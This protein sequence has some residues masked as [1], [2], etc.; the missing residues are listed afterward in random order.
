MK[1]KIL[2]RAMLMAACAAGCFVVVHALA[3][4]QRGYI[5][6]GGELVCLM[7][8]PLGMSLLEDKS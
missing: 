4:M 3:T 8:I 7:A 5:A 1:R 2:K 6:W